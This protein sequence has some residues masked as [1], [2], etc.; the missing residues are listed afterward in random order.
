M[1]EQ[2]NK[3]NPNDWRLD[4]EFYENVIDAVEER[5]DGYKDLKT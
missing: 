2:K 1:A 5:A 3:I 4:A